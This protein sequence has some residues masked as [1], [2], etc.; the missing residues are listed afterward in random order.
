MWRPAW[1]G[2]SLKKSS[3]VDGV[4]NKDLPFRV[5]KRGTSIGP[6]AVV[7]TQLRLR[8]VW[9]ILGDPCTLRRAAL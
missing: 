3:Q 6:C 1:L 2:A 5:E 8:A 4:P 7:P 9:L